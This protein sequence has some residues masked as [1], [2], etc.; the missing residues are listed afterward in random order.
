[1]CVC[2][3]GGDSTP[4]K[5]IHVS[6]LEHIQVC[7]CVCVYKHTQTRLSCNILPI[8]CASCEYPMNISISHVVCN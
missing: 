6:N 4:S 7:V 5:S 1:M 3:E 2:G 8:K